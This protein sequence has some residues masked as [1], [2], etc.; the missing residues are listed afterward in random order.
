MRAGKLR[1]LVTLQERSGA[2]DDLGQQRDDW[3][4]RWKFWASIESTGGGETVAADQ[5]RPAATHKI[6]G[7]WRAG[8]LTSNR[9]VYGERI[10][11][12]QH[13]ANVGERGRDLELICGEGLTRG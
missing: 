12:I 9:I 2:L 7:R 10:F 13:V 1:H 6:C 8:I 11:D 3:V 5:E 4:T